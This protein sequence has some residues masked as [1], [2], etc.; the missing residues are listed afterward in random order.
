MINMENREMNFITDEKFIDILNFLKTKDAITIELLMSKFNI[1]NNYASMIIDDL[2]SIGIV[3]EFN[4]DTKDRKVL[5]K[6]NKQLLDEIEMLKFQLKA[7][8]SV[9]GQL[10]KDLYLI[11][12]YETPLGFEN[13]YYCM[14]NIASDSLAKNQPK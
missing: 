8:D 5:T 13:D 7:A 2:E 11:S 1:G 9:N 4:N 14:I 6:Q 3:S 10:A 12:T